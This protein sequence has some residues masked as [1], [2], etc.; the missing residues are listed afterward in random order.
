M[1]IT[2]DLN[3]H[4][5]SAAVCSGFIALIPNVLLLQLADVVGLATA[6]GGLLALMRIP[7]AYLAGVIGLDGF[8][9]GSVQ[10]WTQS[11]SFQ[12]GFHVFVAIGMAVFYVV[13]LERR[14]RMSPLFKGLLYGA[15]VWLLNAL[16][17]LPETGE[18][19]IGLKHINAVGAIWF[20]VAHF[21]FFVT[22][23]CAFSSIIKSRIFRQPTGS[24]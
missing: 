7:A 5:S 8:W 10:P 6:H 3:S 22:L 2:H 20:A 19:F 23:A 24:K 21:A 1:D 12:L 15:A 17:V 13:F 9:S 18:G 11:P 16:F 4:R 14:L